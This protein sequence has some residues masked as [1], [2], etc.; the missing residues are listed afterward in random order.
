MHVALWYKH[1]KPIYGCARNNGGVVECSFA[2]ETIELKDPKD[3]GGKIQVGD[4]N[5][6]HIL[7]STLL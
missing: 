6:P 7:R 5:V 2:Y 4:L 1:G 3:V